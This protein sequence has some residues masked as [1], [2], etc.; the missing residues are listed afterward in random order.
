VRCAI[1]RSFFCICWATVARLVGSGGARSWWRIV[2][3][4]HQLLISIVLESGPQ[5]RASDRVVAGLC[6]LLHALGRLIRSAI[7]LKPS[8]LLHLLS[9]RRAK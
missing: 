8:T 4:E 2:L 5:V 6:A 7:V 1:S 9:V 3:V